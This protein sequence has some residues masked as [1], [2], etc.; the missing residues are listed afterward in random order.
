[1]PTKVDT[2][3]FRIARHFIAAG[4][5]VSPRAQSLSNEPVVRKA[6]RIDQIQYGKLWIFKLKMYQILNNLAKRGYLRFC[7][8]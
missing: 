2:P 7:H 5:V 1:M 6:V 8:N 3:K 4:L